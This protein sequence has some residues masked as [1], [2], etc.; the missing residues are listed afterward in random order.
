MLNAYLNG[1]GAFIRIGWEIQCLPY[2]GFF[3]S[4]DQDLG[5]GEVSP[6]Q[7]TRWMFRIQ[8]KKGSTIGFYSPTFNEPIY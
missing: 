3:Y 4:Q 1:I 7:L 2:A 6:T 8:L 5:V